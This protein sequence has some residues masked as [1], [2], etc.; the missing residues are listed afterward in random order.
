VLLFSYYEQL[1]L[2]LLIPDLGYAIYE[3]GKDL[4]ACITKS[5]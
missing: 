4:I 2:V 3:S 1:F 5:I